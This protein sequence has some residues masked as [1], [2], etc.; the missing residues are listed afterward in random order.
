MVA[1]IVIGVALAMLASVPSFHAAFGP[2]LDLGELVITLIFTAELALRVWVAVEDRAGRYAHPLLGRLRYLLTPLAIVDLIAI[3]P[4]YLAP[5]L[6][7]NLLFLRALRIVRILKLFRYSETL[8][9]FQLVVYNQRAALLAGAM[10][11][12]TAAVVIAG[13]AYALEGRAQPEHFGTIP[14]SLWWT[15]VT[16][17]TVGYGDVVPATL[18]GRILASATAFIGITMFAFPTAILGAGFARELQ[19]QSFNSIMAMVARVP[20]FRHLSASQLAEIASQLNLRH[21]PPRYNVIRAGEHGDAMYFIDHGHVIVRSDHG[22]R[23]LGP[24]DYFGEFAL[25]SGTTRTETATTLQSCRLLE[26]RSTNLFRLVADD[27]R[28]KELVDPRAEP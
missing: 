2:W 27:P 24:G 3:L 26:L 13:L 18:L 23:E 21:L 7:G 4:F 16:M 14:D 1:L 19:K 15:I 22:N 28:F 25:L 8:V 17:T 11:I 6:A 10:V 5:F 9:L 12:A 20:R